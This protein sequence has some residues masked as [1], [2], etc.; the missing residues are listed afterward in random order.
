MKQSVQYFLFTL[1]IT[2]ILLAGCSGGKKVS[3][4]QKAFEI[5]EYS[6]AAEMFKRAYSREKNRYNKGEYAYFMGESY[7]LTNKAS[8]AAS[9]Y[10]RAVRYDYP[11]RE[12]QFYLAESYRKTGKLDKAIPEY[13]AYLEEVPADVRAQKGLASAMM[14]LKEPKDNR[15]I[16]EKIKKLNSKYSDFSPAYAGQSYDYVIFS[17]MRT[18][19]KKRKK[20]K[21]TGQGTSSIYYS[22]IDS[23]GEWS[24]PEAFEEPIN[25]N[26]TDDGAPNVSADGKTL[27]FT[28]C[29][30]DKEKPMGAEIFA[31]SRSGGKWV[32]P[33]PVAIAND[34]LTTAHPAIHPDGETLF[35]VSDREGGFGGLDI[36][37]SKKNQDGA[38][39]EPVNAG[40]A[41]NT[42]GNEMFPY[43]REDGLLYF[44]S[45]THIGFG[46]LDIFKAIPHQE[47]EWV[48]SNMGSP[49]NSNSD[50]FGIVFK[51]R[52]EE[53]IFSSSRGSS[54]GIDNLY[55]FVLP[56]LNFSLNGI[57]KNVN[58]EI[59]Q[60]A[61]L[62][63]IGSDGTTMKI[64]TPTD[65][66]FKVKLKPDTDYVFLV[67][68]EGYL[69][70]KVKFS[71]SG[72]TDDKDYTFDI[73]LEKPTIKVQSPR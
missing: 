23:K 28:R 65:G 9:A 18:E 33:T 24:A 20:N 66:A 38:W 34:S 59:V 40:S 15:Y 45:D 21:I 55:S 22:K 69:N 16:V 17:S 64:N 47:K 57:I 67:A 10:S 37:I 50:D 49:I 42:K 44:S 13:E 36:W 51:G 41:I 63:L 62:R 61:Y 19:A 71:T 56:K 48:V 12:A 39:G 30:Y 8:K 31:C 60:G 43:V 11:V 5:G 26:A 35:F 32:E 2:P 25:N 73:T 52:Q 14:M 70:Q 54:K 29:G 53:G 4:A 3:Q 27:Y 1:F 68:A 58:N 72:Q 6:K 7:R 46:G